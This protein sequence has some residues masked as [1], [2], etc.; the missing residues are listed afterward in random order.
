MIVTCGRASASSWLSLGDWRGNLTEKQLAWL[1][2]I[3]QRLREEQTNE[4]RR[5]GGKVRAA[6]IFR[7]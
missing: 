2:A 5:F 3:Y 4:L 7:R 6:R 1:L